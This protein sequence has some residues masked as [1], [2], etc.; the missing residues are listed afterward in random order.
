MTTHF[1]FFFSVNKFLKPKL[2]FRKNFVQ[3]RFSMP[4]MPWGCCRSQCASHS[5][6]VFMA[7]II[8][9]HCGLPRDLH[10]RRNI[11]CNC[12]ETGLRSLMALPPAPRG[13]SWVS[14]YHHAILGFVQ[15]RFDACCR[16]GSSRQH[17]RK[18]FLKQKFLRTL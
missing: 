13:T 4:L 10:G 16:A 18:N 7:R 17:A 1:Q 6:R 5:E 12:Q 11:G 2:F 3:L 8:P 14:R 9:A 15:F